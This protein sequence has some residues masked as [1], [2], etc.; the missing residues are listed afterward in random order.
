M[1]GPASSPERRF[2]HI[3]VRPTAFKWLLEAAC[4]CPRAASRLLHLASFAFAF[5][6][7]NASHC[8]CLQ[9][10]MLVI[11]HMASSLSPSMLLQ[12]GFSLQCYKCYEF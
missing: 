11:V 7:Y 6:T 8:V 5:S 3:G 1:Q 9:Q 2:K 4:P 12:E 10:R